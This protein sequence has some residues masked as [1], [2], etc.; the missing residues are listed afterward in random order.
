MT[1]A[2]SLLQS[3]VNCS[4]LFMFAALLHLPIF[5]SRHKPLDSWT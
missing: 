3:V 4:L 2:V 5:E 1:Q